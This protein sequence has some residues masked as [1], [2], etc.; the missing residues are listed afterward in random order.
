MVLGNLLL[1]EGRFSAWKQLH[2]HVYRNIISC[3]YN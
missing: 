3:H 2:F 1:L